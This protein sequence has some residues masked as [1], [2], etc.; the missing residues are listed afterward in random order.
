[1][2]RYGFCPVPGHGRYLRQPLYVRDFCEIILACVDRP[3]PGESYDIC[4]TESISYIDM[5]RAVRDSAGLRAPV[6]PVPYSVVWL[7]LRSLEALRVKAPFTS[8]QLKALTISDVVEAAD[9]PTIF[10][11]RPTPLRQALKET[12]QHP[13]YSKIALEF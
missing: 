12:F 9:W 1:M 2:Q 7:M 6:V 3:R 5:M 10:G 11:V 4:G 13:V 8:Q